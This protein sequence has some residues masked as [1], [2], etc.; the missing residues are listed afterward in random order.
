MNG[1]MDSK[2]LTTYGWGL[3]LSW[4]KE[5][6]FQILT[7][8][9]AAAVKLWRATISLPQYIND[10]SIAMNSFW[11]ARLV[12]FEIS[13]EAKTETDQPKKKNDSVKPLLHFKQHTDSVYCKP[14]QHIS[15]LHILQH[16]MCFIRTSHPV[17]LSLSSEQ[18]QWGLDHDSKT[19]GKKALTAPRQVGKTSYHTCV[20]SS[21]KS[22]LLQAISTQFLQQPFKSILWLAEGPWS[23]DR[24][25]KSSNLSDTENKTSQTHSLCIQA[26]IST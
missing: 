2:T 13:C 18:D 7:E 22:G 12:G 19:W 21:M 1:L 15:D 9:S 6:N 23:P 10:S 4:W 24:H 3:T 26:M 5:T 14:N 11:V 16:P 25:R 17:W 20:W 8:D